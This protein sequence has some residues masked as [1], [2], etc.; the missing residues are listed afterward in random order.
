MLLMTRGLELTEFAKEIYKVKC[1]AKRPSCMLIDSSR[2]TWQGI[3]LTKNLKR[4]EDF[5]VLEKDP[6]FRKLHFC[7]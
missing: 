7:F 5:V 6:D 3:P 4:K 2:K 1:I